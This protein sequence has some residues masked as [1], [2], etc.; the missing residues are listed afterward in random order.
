MCNKKTIIGTRENWSE[1]WDGLIIELESVELNWK[2]GLQMS[3]LNN[4]VVL[5][6][7]LSFS[8]VLL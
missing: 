3:R 5:M 2:S 4:E 7:W 1:Y 6:L 8:E